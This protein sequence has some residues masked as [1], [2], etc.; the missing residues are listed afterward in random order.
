MEAA[1]D[2][3]GTNGYAA[4]SI[5]QLCTAA[6][7][8]TRNFYEEFRTREELLVAL[9]DELNAEA[10]AAVVEAIAHID[11]DDLEARAR[12]GAEAYFRV[13]TRDRRWAR[14]ALVE[15]VG[16]SQTA[17]AHRREAVGRFAELLRLE[18]TRL[19]DAGLIPRRDYALSSVAV[20]GAINGLANTWTAD[21]DW[22]SRFD[23][24]VAEAARI[25]V[26]AARYS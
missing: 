19:G 2:A 18:M 1:V 26:A 7:I 24:V 14:I 9:H 12:S 3:F 23:D 6:G 25:I 20:V 11:P 16:V 5:E 22:Q 4:T 17:E 13:M 10:M 8:S 15:S 21:D